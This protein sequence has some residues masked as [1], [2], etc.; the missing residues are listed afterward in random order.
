MNFVCC[1]EIV[2]NSKNTSVDIKTNFV[3]LYIRSVGLSRGEK[4]LLPASV[5]G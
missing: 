1:L 3:S 2:Y 4:Y 5:D